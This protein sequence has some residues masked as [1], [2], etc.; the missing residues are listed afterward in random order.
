MPTARQSVGDLSGYVPATPANPTPMPVAPGPTGLERSNV[1][2][3]CLPG[4]SSGPD[5]VIRQFN[6]GR[7]APQSRIFVP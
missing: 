7:T 5:A 4:V 1:M 2:L 3:A 6:G